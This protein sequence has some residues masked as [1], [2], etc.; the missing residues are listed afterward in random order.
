MQRHFKLSPSPQWKCWVKAAIA[1][2]PKVQIHLQ[3]YRSLYFSDFPQL[4]HLLQPPLRISSWNELSCQTIEHM[5][6]KLNK[7]GEGCSNLV[8]KVCTERLDNKTSSIRRH[9]AIAQVTVSPQ[10]YTGATVTT[11]TLGQHFSSQMS[12][13]H[14]KNCTNTLGIFSHTSLSFN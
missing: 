1:R 10:H 12:M 8:W 9:K 7:L 11:I 6:N 13:L 14:P 4:K 5:W 2:T 3:F